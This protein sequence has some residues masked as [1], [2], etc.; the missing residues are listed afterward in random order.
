MESIIQ[1]V[2]REISGEVVDTV[3]ARDL[4][5]FIESKQDFSKWIKL[6]I[7]QYGF[8]QGIDFIVP[9]NCGAS[10]SVG[11]AVDK[12]EYF[13]TIDMAKELSMVERNMQGKK[14]RQYFIECEKQVGVQIADP[15]IAAM[16]MMLQNLDAIKQQQS[17]QQKTLIQ[18]SARMDKVEARTNAVLDGAGF[19]SVLG[20]ASLH[21][22]RVDLKAAAS[23]G[24]K[25][26]SESK[27]LGIGTG[28]VPDPRFGTVKT[29]HE[30][31]LRHV[32]AI[33]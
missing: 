32:F 23:Y 27:T 9:Q 6:R 31:V 16:V 7:E 26:A 30:D 20:F 18:Q 29:Y 19:Y 22:I 21:G 14:A 15:Q 10:K 13:I 2:S 3:N 1:L 11:Y 8:T 33:E 12:I 4:W 17:E 5:Q 25:A 28:S 24:R